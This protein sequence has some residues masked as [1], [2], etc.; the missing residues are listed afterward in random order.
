MADTLTWTPHYRV[1]WGG[2]IGNPAQEIWTNTLRFRGDND[3]IGVGAAVLDHDALQAVANALD[4]VLSAWIGGDASAKISSAA[5]LKWVKVNWIDS[6]GH[7]PDTNTII[8]DTVAQPGNSAGG[9]ASWFLSYA[10]TLRT[11]LAR[12]RSHAGRIYPP[13]IALTV[14][15]ASG[16]CSV[17]EATGMATAFARAI[18][19]MEAAFNAE[20]GITDPN[21]HA[22]VASPGSALRGT[23]PLFQRITGVVCDRVPDVMHSRTNAIPRAEGALVAPGP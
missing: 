13:V 16:Y 20:A 18:Y 19:A 2:T 1:S 15:P 7:Q 21:I 10:L 17:G 9:V 11:A 22:I 8:R 6:A 23:P 12:G 14:D 5:S 4:P 3:L